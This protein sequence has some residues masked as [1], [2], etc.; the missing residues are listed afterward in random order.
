M[1]DSKATK[2]DLQIQN[3]INKNKVNESYHKSGYD[4]PTFPKGVISVEPK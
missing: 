2:R 1:L 3:L 4:I